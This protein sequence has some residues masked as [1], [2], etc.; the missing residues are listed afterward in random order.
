MLLKIQKHIHKIIYFNPS[1]SSLSFVFHDDVF[2]DSVCFVMQILGFRTHY[3]M[4]K[5]K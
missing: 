1:A 3:C 5:M 4:D 2:K